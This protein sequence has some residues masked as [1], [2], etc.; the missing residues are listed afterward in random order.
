MKEIEII[1]KAESDII[2]ARTMLLKFI[3]ENGLNKDIIKVAEITTIISEL[4]RNMYH[5][6]NGGKITVK[7]DE[8][9]NTKVKMI[10]SDKGQGFDVDEVL[11][12]KAKKHGLGLGLIGSKRLSDEFH[13]RSGPSGTTIICTK[14]MK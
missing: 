9:D 8:K 13:I 3:K 7:V 1:V 5:Y 10:F 11:S 4:A 14:Q 2:L 12:G 6:A